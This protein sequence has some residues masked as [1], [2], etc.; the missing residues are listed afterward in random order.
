MDSPMYLVYSHRFPHP[1]AGVDHFGYQK[2][3]DSD[4]EKTSFD[5]QTYSGSRAGR[6][7]IGMTHDISDQVLL[8][9]YMYIMRT[10]RAM[11]DVPGRVGDVISNVKQRSS[12]DLRGEIVF[13]GWVVHQEWKQAAPPGGGTSFNSNFNII[14]E[15]NTWL[16]RDST[17]FGFRVMEQKRNPALKHNFRRYLLNQY[18]IDLN[19]TYQREDLVNKL[20][21][22]F[23][24]NHL[25]PR[26]GG[27]PFPNNGST[28]IEIGGV[29]LFPDLPGV[30]FLENDDIVRAVGAGA[31][32]TLGLKF[33]GA[34]DAYDFVRASDVFSGTNPWQSIWDYLNILCATPLYECFVHE[35]TGLLVFRRAAWEKVGSAITDIGKRLAGGLA[36]GGGIQGFAGL[37]SE[38][39]QS[40][41]DL[42]SNSGQLNA[43]E[44][45][46]LKNGHAYLHKL[47]QD[48]ITYLYI[49]KTVSTVKN[50]VALFHNSRPTPASRLANVYFDRFGVR[51]QPVEIATYS[52]KL[53]AR[54]RTF[55]TTSVALAQ[56]ALKAQFLNLDGAMDEFGRALNQT[57]N[58]KQYL[59][60]NIQDEVLRRSVTNMFRGEM[61]LRNWRR[62]SIG[63]HVKIYDSKLDPVAS[64]I[65]E[66]TGKA[67]NQVAGLANC[68]D[69]FIYYV[70]SKRLNVAVDVNGVFSETMALRI[71][72]GGLE[73]FD[74]R[75]D[76]RL[77][78][79]HRK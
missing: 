49:N 6:A 79:Y 53:N 51:Y 40:L 17:L 52:P 30:P 14:L 76:S 35:D 69:D 74:E 66:T 71:N 18:H 36:G 62:I 10:P 63:D 23:I 37:G 26:G 59:P 21:R 72:F 56:G 11:V 67:L 55:G 61:T 4:I 25:T 16:L 50:V 2:D 5:G 7:H 29:T 54:S 38:F 78:I 60:V 3:L 70:T 68:Q 65:N 27:I 19:R 48:E 64:A 39:G 9:D 45:L 31:S 75:N 41:G 20:V 24:K 57:F 1:I 28:E 8:G 15:D 33:E 43:A 34:I 22:G 32:T 12:V 44:N 73:F 46:L 77:K 13:Q 47:E 42:G 58:M